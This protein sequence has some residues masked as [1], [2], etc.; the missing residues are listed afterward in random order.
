[1]SDEAELIDL[2][3]GEGGETGTEGAGQGQA[4]DGSGEGAG[5]AAGETAE[6]ELAGT[7]HSLPKAVADHIAGLTKAAED[8]KAPRAPEAYELTAPEGSDLNLAA[9]D[10]MAAEFMG[11][12]K[13]GDVD[14]ATGQKLVDFLV[15]RE[16]A[17]DEQAATLAKESQAKNLAAMTEALGGEQAVKDLNAWIKGLTGGE[18]LSTTVKGAVSLQKLRERIGEVVPPKEGGG[19][20]GPD[21][22]GAMYP[23]MKG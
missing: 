10:P 12:L 5:A 21:P 13:D 11:I 8:A 3:G 18:V 6:F 2:A 1:M 23:K 17:L 20:G 7:K 22:L 14:T 16:A 15:K 4:A 19:G 9:D